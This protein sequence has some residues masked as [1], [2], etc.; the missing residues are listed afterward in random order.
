[1]Y[2]ATLPVSEEQYFYTE[3]GVFQNEYDPVRGYHGINYEKGMH[4]QGFWEVNIITRGRGMHYVEDRRIEVERGDVFIIPAGM[5]H[6]YA[7]GNGFDVYHI[8][9]SSRFMEKYRADL[10]LL[11]CF[12][13]LFSAEPLMRAAWADPL[14]LKLSEEQLGELE[15]QMAIL[16]GTNKKYSPAFSIR[17]CA[18]ALVLIT[19]LCECYAANIETSLTDPTQDVAFMNALAYIHGHYDEKLTIAAL[20]QMAQLSRSSFLRR[21]RQVCKDTPACY[22]LKRRIEAAKEMLK[23]TNL[24]EEAIGQKTGFYDAAHFIRIFTAETGTTP[25]KYRRTKCVLK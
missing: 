20:A 18:A 8:L 22:I 13:N 24:S 17:R 25:G 10:Q 6:G 23:S 4:V 12:F 21:F 7:G 19:G 1:M 16:Y 3:Q 11:P 2:P 5:R 15:P 14:H 9:I